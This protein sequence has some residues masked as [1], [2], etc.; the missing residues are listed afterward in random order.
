MCPAPSRRAA[1]PRACGAAATSASSG[2]AACGSRAS[3]GGAGCGSSSPAWCSWRPAYCPRRTSAEKRSSRAEECSG[4]WPFIA[5]RQQAD[6][7]RHAQ[8]FAFAGRDE[9]VEHH[10]R[11]VGEIAE[12]RLPQRQRVGLGQRIAVFEAEHGLFRQ[13]RI[14]DFEAGLAVGEIVE[15]RVARSRSP[16][17]PAPN[18]A[19]R[20]CRARSPGR[21]AARGGL[22]A[23]ASRRPA[24][25]RSPSRCRSPVSI[26]LR[27]LSMKRLS[28]WCRWK[29]GGS[30]VIFSPISLSSPRSTPVW[31]RRGSS[32]LVGGLEAGPAAVEP[33]GLVGAIAL[34]G[35]ELGVEPG[36]PIGLHLLDFAGGDDA[37]GDEL[38]AVDFKRRR[39]RAR[40]PCTSAAG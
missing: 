2:S 19:A 37:L 34:R 28:V 40:S 12:L 29:P 27:R 35:L 17:R 1:T 33:V 7:A 36:A 5:V 6:E 18:G 21:T 30:V 39:M 14:D 22:R 24:L 3:A 11:A 32:A 26:A 13:H 8:P 10:L 25:R 31:P 9:L 4:P 20:T 15:R 38:L 23:A 16:D